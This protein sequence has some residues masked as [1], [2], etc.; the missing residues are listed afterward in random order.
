MITPST[1]IP[2][3]CE[4][5]I[6]DTK[7]LEPRSYVEAWPIFRK[8]EERAEKTPSTW[9]RPPGRTGRTTEEETQSCH[10]SRPAKFA[11]PTDGKPEA[12]R[13]DGR[14]CIAKI[15][16]SATSASRPSHRK[17]SNGEESSAAGV[18]SI[19]VAIGPSSRQ[20]ENDAFFDK[21][22]HVFNETSGKARQVDTRGGE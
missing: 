4:A 9:A 14:C 10:H 2:A 16:A 17:A 7:R 22:I 8:N 19:A 6:T 21:S 15:V 13:R 3:S 5:L 11:H 18:V 20:F 1:V 12:K